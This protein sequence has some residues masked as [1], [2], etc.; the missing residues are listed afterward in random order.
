MYSLTDS[1]K[2]GLPHEEAPPQSPN[3]Q[4]LQAGLQQ[5][6]PERED[7]R[8]QHWEDWVESM[9]HFTMWI[10]NKFVTA[11]PSDGGSARI[12]T[13]KVKGADGSIKEVADNAGKSQALYDSF[14]FPPPEDDGLNLNFIYP[15]PKFQF[16][17]ISDMQIL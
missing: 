4:R 9:D 13:L 8:K 2:K 10:I 7:A 14:F 3:H 11:A 5:I 16:C 12:P 15:P 1:G 17:P 6:C